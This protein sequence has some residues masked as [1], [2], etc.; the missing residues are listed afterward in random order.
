MIFWVEY[1]HNGRQVRESSKGFV[2]KA[3]GTRSDG[4][5]RRAAERLLKERRRTA[6]TPHFIGPTAERVTFDDLAALY[7]TDY[8]VNRRRSLDHAE[9]Y[10]R[11]LRA[12]FGLDRALD[13]TADRIAAYTA[14]R[15]ADGLQPGAVNRELAALRRMFSLAVRRC[16]R[17]ENPHNSAPSES[18]LTKQ[19]APTTRNPKWRCAES[20]RGPR[21][22]ESA[23][24]VDTRSLRVRSGRKYAGSR[25]G[26]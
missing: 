16:S 14:Q 7:L 5:E 20:N 24:G 10:V 26:E 3:D 22:Y 13:V 9:R 17:S 18:R 19:A 8:K 12:T 1:W 4:T 23:P 21:D 15:L 25:R 11:N 6:G 2:Y